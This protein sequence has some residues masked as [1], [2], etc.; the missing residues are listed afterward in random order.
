MDPIPYK[1]P[2]L[3]KAI[4]PL[5]KEDYKA[6]RGEVC[7]LITDLNTKYA[8]ENFVKG[9][10][11]DFWGAMTEDSLYYPNLKRGEELTLVLRGE[12]LAMVQMKNLKTAGK[13]RSPEEL[14]F[15]NYTTTG[16]REGSS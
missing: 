3:I 10:D 8:Y 14:N 9:T 1:R 15:A 13:P 2:Y 11:F 6:G 16:E 7:T 4:I 12:L 5:S